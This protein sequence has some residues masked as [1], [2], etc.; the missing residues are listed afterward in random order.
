[1]VGVYQKN[2]K[3]LVGGLAFI[4]PRPRESVN[5]RALPSEGCVEPAG[6]RVMLMRDGEPTGRFQLGV[7]AFLGLEVVSIWSRV[8]CGFPQMGQGRVSPILRWARA[9]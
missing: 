1:M 6:A 5:A 4:K 9:E 7:L 2:R 3:P 8:P